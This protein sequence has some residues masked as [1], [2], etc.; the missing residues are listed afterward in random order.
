MAER[1]EY[2]NTGSTW[3]RD[4]QLATWVAQTFTPAIAHK[5]TSV[6]LQLSRYGL[7][8]T[9]TVGIRETDVD[10]KPT[11]GDLCSGTTDG[12]TL[13]TD[14]AGGWREITLGAGYNL[15]ADTKY[16]IVVRAL[17]GDGSNFAR[18]RYDSSGDYDGGWHLTS[19]DSGTYWTSY[20]GLDCMFEDWG[21]AIIA[22]VG[23]SFGFVFG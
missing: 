1:Y 10:G 2:Y 19:G 8:G 12:D 15:D 9:I 21:E 7:P 5:I 23:R 18:W 16:A 17:E 20:A 3:Y 11:G 6:K 13:T 4:F 14:T 22:A